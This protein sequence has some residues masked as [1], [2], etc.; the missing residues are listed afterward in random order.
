MSKLKQISIGGF[1]TRN[2]V[3]MAPMA[4]ITDLP[5]REICVNF[6]AGL[7]YTEM[8]SAKGL[9][10]DSKNTNELLDMGNINGA[11]QIFGS[12]PDI[13]AHAAKMLDTIDSVVLIDINMG[14]PA[15]KI[16]KNG[17]GSALMKNPAL[18][19][20]IVAAVSNA[21]KKP[22]TVKIRKGFGGSDN[23]VEIAKIAEGNGARAVTV[24]GRTREQFYSGEADWTAIAAVKR[25]VSIPV[26]GNGDVFTPQAA[27]RLLNETGCD[28]V[29]VARGALGNPW[30]LAG[31]VN[32]L[33]TGGL[34]VEPSDG[35]RISAAVKHIRRLVEYKGEFI[36]VREARKHVCW[37]IKGIRGAGAV[38]VL[39]NRAETLGEMEGILAGLSSQSQLRG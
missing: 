21:T 4:G 15:P 31:T 6:G 39:V 22:V 8:V 38:R 30:L 12:E 20:K 9:F 18:V 32:Y 19:G 5:F 3:F 23:A 17:E 36:G 16:V 10:Y 7:T 13:M 37:Y 29:M 28:G 26:I 2:N 33:Q 25:A 34:D 35:E 1:I 27:E 24:H 14:C 11:A